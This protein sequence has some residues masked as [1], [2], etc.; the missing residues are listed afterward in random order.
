MQTRQVTPYFPPNKT[1]NQHRDVHARTLYVCTYGSPYTLGTLCQSMKNELDGYTIFSY[2][3]MVLRSRGPS[4]RAGA[5]LKRYGDR[6]SPCRTPLEI[7]K[8]GG[9]YSI[10][11]Y[12]AR[13]IVNIQ[14]RYYLIA[15]L[16][17]LYN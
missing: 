5:P 10:V 15:E 16:P 4:A 3:S 2:Q 1:A 8:E 13:Y 11:H 14:I 7:C 17:I 9:C 6:G 12:A